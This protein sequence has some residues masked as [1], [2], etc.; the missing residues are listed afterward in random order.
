MTPAVLVVDD[1]LTVR[2][3]LDDAFRNGGFATTLCA[4][5]AA[6]RDAM[7]RSPFTLVVLDVLLPDA[8]GIDFLRELKATPGTANVPVM[9]LSTEA[10]VRDRVRGLKTGAEEYIGKPYDSTYV[11]S[12]ARELVRKLQPGPQEAETPKILVID[13]SVTFRNELKTAL[14]SKGYEVVTVDNG[15]EGLRL[16]AGLRPRAIIVDGVLPGI[17]GASVIRRLRQDAALRRT[18]SLLL[19]AS[20][21]PSGELRA[22]DAGADAY[23]RKEEDL[24]VILAR[25][26]AVLRSSDASRSVE[27]ASS[28]LGPKKVLAVDDSQ[29]YLQEIAAQLRNDGYEPIL[30]RSG[31]E[32]LELLAVQPV[33]CILLDVLMPGLSGHETCRRIKSSPGWRDIPTLMLTAREERA[34]MI[35]GINSGADDY[36]P[37]SSDFEVLKA[38]LRA[39]L[40]RKQF[41]DENRH[42]REQLLQTEFEAAQARASRELADT[43]AKLLADLELKNKELESFSYSVSHDLRAPLRAIDGFSR[44]LLDGHAQR[45]DGEGTRLLGVVIENTRRMG[46]LIDDLLRFSRLGSTALQKARVDMTS[47]AQ[48]VASELL[49]SLP[50]RRIELSVGALGAAHGDPS[51]LRQ[52]FQNLVGNAIKYS[53]T[54]EVARIEVRSRSEGLETV[55]TVGDNGVGFD[56]EYVHKLFG[57]FQ[58]LHSAKEFE[59]TGVGLAL[60]KRIIERHGGRVWAEGKVD[61]GAS[62][63]FTLPGEGDSNDRPQ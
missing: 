47:L 31:E 24:Q 19:T 55:Y 20:E 39:Q 46:Q 38:R 59:G 1:S 58:R 54:R 9:L 27:A 6:A 36:I 18:P 25:L 22:L 63:H 17:D 8:D 21:D 53:R 23:V 34:D 16:A 4:T 37:K 5:A 62:I 44:M 32:A 51:L 49:G 42:I 11:V 45:L 28:L 50:G 30:A 13:D 14:E 60:V 15:E 57:V 33:D 52:V 56:M 61:Q 10:E 26:A 12:R 2:M 48:S 29:T 35:E 43:R 40:R 7:A 41:E 3:D